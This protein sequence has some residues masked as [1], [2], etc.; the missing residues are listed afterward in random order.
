MRSS[1]A[2]EIRKWVSRRLKTLPGMISRLRRMA[3]ATNS[4][5]VP[6]GGAGEGVEGPLGSGE[7][8]EPV[9]RSHHGVAL[10]T[11]RVDLRGQVLVERDD[12]GVLHQARRTDE[13]ELLELGHLLDDAAGPMGIPEPPAGHTV[14]LAEA[15]D[16]QHVF[17]PRRRRRERVVVAERAI[18]LVADQQNPALA[19]KPRECL[20]L[21][22]RGDDAVGF[23]G[24]LA[25]THLV[26]AVIA[27]ATLAMSIRKSG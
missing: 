10:A 9:E 2:Y 1:T 13:A 7:V 14:G 8:D 24:E 16:D 21:A 12:P 25:M 5:A 6:Q 19:A 18:H 3:S 26:R 23:A 15:V 4:V 17:V 11:V 22:G 20:H 27:A